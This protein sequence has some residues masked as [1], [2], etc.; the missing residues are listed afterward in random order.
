MDKQPIP[1]LKSIQDENIWKLWP[2]LNRAMVYNKMGR[3]ELALK[4]YDLA[5]YL[6]PELRNRWQW[7]NLY[8]ITLLEHRRIGSKQYKLSM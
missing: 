3:P 6:V 7:L 5:K 2:V 1:A 8:L 4:D